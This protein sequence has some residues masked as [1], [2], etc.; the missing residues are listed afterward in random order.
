MFCCGFPCLFRR[1]I[2]LRIGMPL[3]A[4]TTTPLFGKWQ[5]FSH[6]VV[7]L[8]MHTSFVLGDL[9]TSLVFSGA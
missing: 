4:T 1:A 7:F 3:G 9:H 6:Q 8:A 2:S 5:I